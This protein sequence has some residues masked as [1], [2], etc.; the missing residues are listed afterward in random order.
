MTHKETVPMYPAADVADLAKRG[1]QIIDA[2]LYSINKFLY[3]DTE[4]PKE[5]Q[6]LIMYIAELEEIVEEKE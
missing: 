5:Q 4:M 2:Y 6:A 3:L 1:K